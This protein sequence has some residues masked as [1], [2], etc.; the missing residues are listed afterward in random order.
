MSHTPCRAT[1][2]RWC[3]WPTRREWSSRRRRRIEPIRQEIENLELLHTG[4][5][6][7]TTVAEVTS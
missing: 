1:V 6:V 5:D 2:S 7:P 3:R 4:A